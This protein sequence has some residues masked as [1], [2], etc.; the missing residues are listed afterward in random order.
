MI[1]SDLIEQELLNNVISIYL[2][3]NGYEYNIYDIIYI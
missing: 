3:H 1:T 2:A